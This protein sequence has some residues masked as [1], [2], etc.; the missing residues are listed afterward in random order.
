VGLGVGCG[1]GDGV[2]AGVGAGVGVAVGAGVGVAVGL[3]VGDGERAATLLTMKCV[4]APVVPPTLAAS[5]VTT[6]VEQPQLLLDCRW[7]QMLS[8]ARIGTPQPPP[9][10]AP[11]C[12]T[13]SGEPQWPLG[14]G[15]GWWL[16]G[17]LAQS[18]TWPLAAPLSVTVSH[19]SRGPVTPAHFAFSPRPGAAVRDAV[20]GW[21]W[22]GERGVRGR[23][24]ES[25]L[26]VS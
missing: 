4:G 14:G 17:E 26:V 20:R 9:A 23:R 12:I 19:A 6:Q 3:G 24:E 2:G 11:S 13:L 7:N 21:W 25:A 15:Q 22:G 10:T 1:V 18:L 8:P 5:A 16:H